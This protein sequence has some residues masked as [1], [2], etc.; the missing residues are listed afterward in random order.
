[1]RPASVRVRSPARPRDPTRSRTPVLRHQRGGTSPPEG[2]CAG[3]GAG[4]GIGAVVALTAQEDTTGRP[5]SRWCGCA[6]PRSPG[7]RGRR[8]TRGSRGTPRSRGAPRTRGTQGRRGAHGSP[9]NPGSGAGVG[10]RC[11]GRRPVAGHWVCHDA[12][13]CHR[14]AHHPPGTAVGVGCSCDEGVDAQGRAPGAGDRRGPWSALPLGRRDRSRG[15]GSVVGPQRGSAAERGPAGVS[16]ACGAMTR[17]QA[18]RRAAGA[19]GGLGRG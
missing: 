5:Q 15:G 11:R 6:N 19:R 18:G 17:P 13:A 4:R 14:S 12:L 9:G 8:G 10:V 16:A 7:T 3:W 1:M 2:R